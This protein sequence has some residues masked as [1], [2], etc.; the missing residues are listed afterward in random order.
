MQEEEV[1]DVIT[2][3]GAIAGSDFNDG[4]KAYG[5]KKA[6]DIVGW[7]HKARKQQRSSMQFDDFVKGVV[8]G[9][10]NV[11]ESSKQQKTFMKNARGETD[12]ASE[13]RPFIQQLGAV[14]TIV[15]DQRKQAQMKAETVRKCDLLWRMGSIQH[16]RFVSLLAQHRVSKDPSK[17]NQPPELRVMYLEAE[18]MVRSN[19]DEC[20]AAIRIVSISKPKEIGNY[21]AEAVQPLSLI[22]I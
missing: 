5:Y 20:K 22:H 4:L 11:I 15:R 16:G 3:V 2:C 1:E 6:K 18:R 14:F 21:K 13:V 7:L 8:S 19:E 17:D 10:V 9:E 12:Q